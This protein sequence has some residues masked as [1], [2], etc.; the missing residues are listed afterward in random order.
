MTYNHKRLGALAAAQ[1][2]SFAIVACLGWSGI[3]TTASHPVTP[4]ATTPAVSKSQTAITAEV[5]K[6]TPKSTGPAVSVP[7]TPATALPGPPPTGA[8][9]AS[10]YSSRPSD[11]G[12]RPPAASPTSTDST[13]GTSDGGDASSTGEDNQG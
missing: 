11:P 5:P 8:V 2:G 13:D 6:R 9:P 3:G 1:F 10:S 4:A 12:T 7:A